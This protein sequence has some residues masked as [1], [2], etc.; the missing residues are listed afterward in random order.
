MSRSA[1]VIGS[2]IIGVS[3]AH[4]LA[5]SGWKVSIIDRGRFAGGCSHANCGL[6]CPSHILPLAE[7]G[8]VRRTMAAMLSKNSPFYIK[9][10]LDLALWAWMWNFARR[11]NLE[12]MIEAGRALGPLLESSMGI[13]QQLGLECEWE[14]RGLMF[15]YGDRAGLDAYEASDRMLRESFNH[16]ARKLD[17]AELAAMEPALVD[18][19]AGA[20]FYESDAHLRPDRLMA[21]WKRKLENRGVVIRENCEVSGFVSENG[22]ARAVKTAMGELAGDAFVLATGAWT[23][24]LSGELGCRLPIQPGKG[25]SMTMTRPTICP[26]IPLIFPETKVAVTPM[27]SGYRLGSMMEFAGYDESLRPERLALLKRGAEPFLKEPYTE[28]VEEQWFGWRPMTFDGVPIIDFA[29]AMRNVLIAAGHNMIGMSTGPGT[30]RLVAEMLGDGAT[31][32][33]PRPYSLRRF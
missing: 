28:Q 14:K 23:P 8:A 31:F 15:V 27:Q 13:F 12:C 7:P 5:E 24:L 11:C 20:W 1:L 25:Y 30:G 32:I 10:R 29:P 16:P 21:A 9:P 4:F 19:L 33:D 6:I 26:K 22:K 17:G 18:G 2:G 3:S